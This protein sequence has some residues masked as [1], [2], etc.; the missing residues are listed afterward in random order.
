MSGQDAVSKFAELLDQKGFDAPEKQFILNL[1][2]LA[3]TPAATPTKEAPCGCAKCGRECADTFTYCDKCWYD[4]QLEA[5]KKEQVGPE[6]RASREELLQL[7]NDA[8][9][10]IGPCDEECGNCENCDFV[11]DA[12]AVRVAEGIDVSS[13]P[14]PQ[15]PGKKDLLTAVSIVERWG[16]E[17]VQ[18]PVKVGKLHELI[19]EALERERKRL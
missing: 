9:G 6:P 8:Y 16:R 4:L 11:R 15:E 5:A 1:L 19:A 10:L 3:T 18:I 17:I 2:A 7:V 14:Q 13:E 12:H